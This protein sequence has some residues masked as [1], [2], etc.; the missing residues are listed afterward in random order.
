MKKF[1]MMLM[2]A[3]VMLFAG[4]TTAQAQGPGGFGGGNPDE[5]VKMR[6]DRMKETLKIN[7]DQ[8][9]KLT[10]LFK[11]QNEEM[12]KMFQS[13]ERPDRSQMEETRKKQD[14]EIKKIL[15]AEQYKLY[16]EEQQRMREQFGRGPGGGGF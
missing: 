8:E 11:K 7:S 14:E 6:I 10:A 3:G 13:G 5:M 1:F 16:T 15:T 2:A 12:A 9:A 4:M